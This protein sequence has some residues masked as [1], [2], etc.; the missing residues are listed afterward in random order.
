MG[1]GRQSA[2]PTA[3]PRSLVPTEDANNL[4]G[5]VGFAD[6]RPPLWIDRGPPSQRSSVDPRL[7]PLI[8][9]PDPSTKVAG[10]LL[11]YRRAWS[12][13]WGSRLAAPTPN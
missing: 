2:A 12:S 1:R 13:D 11:R 10:V 8:G 3:Q 6:W 5:G 9:Y 4:G 7:G